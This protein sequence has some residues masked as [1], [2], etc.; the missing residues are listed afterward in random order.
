MPLSEQSV[1]VATKDQVSCDLDGEAAILHIK[2]G[3]YYGLDPVGAWV[4]KLI[5]K[6]QR[7]GE[8]RDAMLQSY[9]VESEQAQRDVVSLL[10]DM[11]AQGLIEVRYGSAL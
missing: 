10:E 1:V 7:V 4:W 5:Q 6:P 8:I 2:K 3:V 9:D 11:L